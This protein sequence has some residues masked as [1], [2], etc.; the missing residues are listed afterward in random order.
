M[1]S[2]PDASTSQDQPSGLRIAVMQPGDKFAWQEFV[3]RRPDAGCMHH[4]GWHAVLCEAYWVTPY[5]LMAKDTCG[6]IAGILPLYH[7]RSPLTGP[8]LSSLEDGVLADHHEAAYALLAEA[9]ALRDSTGARYLQVRGGVVDRPGAI[10]VP[11]V[12]TFIDTDRPTDALW[13]AVKKKTRWAIRQA[14]KTNICIDCDADLIGLED[15]YRVYAEHMRELGTP[16]IGMDAF[17]AIRSHLGAQR[18]RLYQVRER[19]R[20]IGGMLCIVNAN[21]WTDY[22]AIM[23]PSDETVFANYF[24][25]WQVIRDAAACGVPLLDL[26]RSTPD[27]NV[28]LFKRKWGGRDLEVMYQFYP[29]A[30]AELR[31]VQLENLKK[32]KSLMQRLWSRLPLAVC[33]RLGP[34]LRKQLPFI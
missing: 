1:K 18:L 25:Y 13:S 21:R 14:E 7:S 27:S 5:F 2:Q 17:R 11:T 26:G 22:Y 29:A 30:N 16:V 32:N 10:S 12:R 34:L 4:A 8:Y 23:R 31:G 9:R 19:Q 33:N 15:F 28:H 6:R 24:L 3:D 20:L